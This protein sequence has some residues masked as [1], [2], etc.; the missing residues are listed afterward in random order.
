MDAVS[1]KFDAGENRT[2]SCYACTYSQSAN[3]DVDG[4]EQCG[5]SV[6][7]NPLDS[8]IPTMNC[9]MYANAGCYQ[10]SAT[11]D[12]YVDA[13]KSFVDDYR[14]CSTFKHP[15]AHTDDELHCE[16]TEINELSHINCKCKE[17]IIEISLIHF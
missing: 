13:S 9:P 10:A 3:G 6:N 5:E 14:G 15:I 16:A 8:K 2:E 4:F 17:F 11:H 1:Y 12:D 7:S